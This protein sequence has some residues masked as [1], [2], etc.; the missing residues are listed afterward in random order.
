MAETITFREIS[1]AARK[2]LTRGH[3]GRRQISE[4]YAAGR[5]QTP[6]EG[7]VLHGGAQYYVSYCM[8][9][10]VSISWIKTSPLLT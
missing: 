2:L 5:K 1:E 3:D 6:P 10:V 8:I 7:S 4:D 9:N